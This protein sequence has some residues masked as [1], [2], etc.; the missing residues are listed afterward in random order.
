MKHPTI[1]SVWLM[2]IAI[3]MAV[4]YFAF[5]GVFC[6]LKHSP[7]STKVAPAVTQA[8]GDSLPDD[9]LELQVF[10]NKH[11]YKGKDGLV[12][13]EDGIFGINT[14]Y[15]K[16]RYIGDESAAKWHSVLEVE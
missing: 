7:S 14:E 2:A 3:C 13:A 8:A 9:T 4:W 16:N 11:R 12:L 10:L 6:L 15:A 5:V 1:V